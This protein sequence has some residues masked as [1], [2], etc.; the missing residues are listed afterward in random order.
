M[1]TIMDNRHT[2]KR[3]QTHETIE[4]AC[5]KGIDQLVLIL[6]NTRPGVGSDHHRRWGDKI[7]KKYRIARV[8]THLVEES[9]YQTHLD[10]NIWGAQVVFKNSTHWPRCCILSKPWPTSM[11]HQHIKKALLHQMP[12][13][14]SARMQ[15]PT[16]QRSHDS[17]NVMLVPTKTSQSL[18]RFGS[19]HRNAS[20]MTRRPSKSSKSKFRG[21][22][23]KWLTF[24]TVA[25]LNCLEIFVHWRKFSFWQLREK[26]KHFIANRNFA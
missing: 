1:K 18:F 14:R 26:F 9:D 23:R 2:A 15:W 13:C 3:S 10:A 4:V 11:T 19:L 8:F 12:A 21:I 24:T 17:Q 16:S 6:T 5:W 25:S 20:Q 7:S 22:S